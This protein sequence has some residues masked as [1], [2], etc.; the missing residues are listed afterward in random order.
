MARTEKEFLNTMETYIKITQDRLKDGRIIDAHDELG[1]M[2]KMTQQ[3]LREVEGN[4]PWEEIKGKY[5]KA[6][7]S[8]PWASTRSLEQ[9]VEDQAAANETAEKMLR[10]PYTKEENK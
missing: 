2:L 4:A 10:E 9:M 8:H 7:K 5:E 3:R 6:V 1:T